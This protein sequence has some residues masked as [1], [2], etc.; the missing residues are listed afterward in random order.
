MKTVTRSTCC[1]CGVG[2]GVLIET[3]DER[4]TGV[5]GDPE[6]PANFG[7]LCSKGLALAD[8]ARSQ[9]GAWSWLLHRVTGVGVLVFLLRHIV[10]NEVSTIPGFTN[11]SMYPLAFKASGV[12][13]SELIDRLIL[14]A[15][16]RGKASR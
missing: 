4:I 11:I 9:T 7:K 15:L 14:H 16:G 3:E 13:Y 8:S 10:V 6:H 1:Y 12:S 5:R 2:C